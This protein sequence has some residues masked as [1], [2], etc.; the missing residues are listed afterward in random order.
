MRGFLLVI[1]YPVRAASNF[2]CFGVVIA[3]IYII[4]LGGIVLSVLGKMLNGCSIDDSYHDYSSGG[5]TNTHVPYYENSSS[6]SSSSS[7]STY[8]APPTS[9]T[10]VA[11]SL[12]SQGYR[13][14]QIRK[15]LK[16]NGYGEYRRKDIKRMIGK[17]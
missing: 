3:F 14:G 11:R 15:Y 5:N 10:S 6:S 12:Y 8:S 7:R 17:R 1:F 2:G 9:A 16:N 13:V 4:I